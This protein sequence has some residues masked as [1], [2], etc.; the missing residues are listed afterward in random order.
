VVTTGK[1]VIPTVTVW[2]EDSTRL[3]RQECML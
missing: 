1:T 2:D 3:T